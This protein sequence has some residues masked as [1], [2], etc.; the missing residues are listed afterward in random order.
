LYIRTNIS[1]NSDNNLNPEGVTQKLNV[2]NN[3]RT[4]GVDK[5]IRLVP[6]VISLYLN[7]AHFT[8]AFSLPLD[9]QRSSSNL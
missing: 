2:E 7:L 4:E 8:S 5:Y 6:M 1:Y 9:H 3:L